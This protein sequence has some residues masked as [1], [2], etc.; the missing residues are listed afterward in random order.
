M[1]I[2]QLLDELPRPAYVQNLRWDVIAWNAA[3]DDLFQFGSRDLRDRNLLYL[4]FA[5][6][7]MRRRLPDWES[8]APGLMAQFKYDVATAPEDPTMLELI[9][10]LQSLAPSFRRE[11]A[12]PRG[13]VAQRGLSSLVDVGGTLHRFHHET[14]IV[15]EY[16]HLRMVVYL[17]A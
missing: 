15:D 16:R 5:A 4:A 12:E 6:P 11:W 8:D 17:Q 7:D 2:Q 3:A 14:L 13:A 1:G 10:T 9:E